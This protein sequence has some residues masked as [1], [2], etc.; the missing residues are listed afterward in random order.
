MTWS[1]GV[2]K[3]MNNSDLQIE[4]VKNWNEWKRRIHVDDY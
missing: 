3:D 4:I 1:N 2:E